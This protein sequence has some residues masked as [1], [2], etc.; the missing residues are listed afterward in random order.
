[1]KAGVIDVAMGGGRRHFLPKEVTDEEGK[2]GK[3]TD[4]RNLIEEAK[5]IGAQYVYDDATAAS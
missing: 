5:A 4:G 2:T 3:R 1:M